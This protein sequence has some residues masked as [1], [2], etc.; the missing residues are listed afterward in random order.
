MGTAEIERC[1]SS[2]A[3][4]HSRKYDVFVSFRG[5]DIR[6][7]FVAHLF[8][9]LKQAGI[10]YFKD[11]DKEETGIFIEPKLLDVIRNSRVALFVFTTNYA[12]SWWCLNELVEILECSRR[13]RDHH[14]VL[15]IFYDVEP[16]DVRKQ[17]EGDGKGFG[18]RLATHSDD[19][20]VQK[21]RDALQES[22]NLSGWHLN[23]EANGDQSNFTEQIVGHF[24]RI[25]PRSIS[26][27]FVKNAIG[28]DSFVE[29]MISLLEIG[30]KDDVRVVG[31]WGMK[32]NGKT[33][34]AKVVCDR[35]FRE[36][37]GASLLENVGDA[38]Q[39]TLLLQKRLRHDV[40]KVQGLEMYDLNSNINEIK[41]KL[42]R[43]GSR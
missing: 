36:F 2:S 24:F 41:T 37:E 18:R 8:H 30:L 17:S 5:E 34:V 14:V 22:G 25:S 9:A 26:P 28:V 15:P 42:C 10:H 35:I 39:D 32:G 43:K 11:T 38:N 31:L 29:D 20:L 16:G 7:T 6:K 19:L 27:Y 4:I 13:F 1:I 12:N 40:L 3:S 23:N 33:T 21:W